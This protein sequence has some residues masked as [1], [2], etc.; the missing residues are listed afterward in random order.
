MLLPLPGTVK[1]FMHPAR[2]VVA[3][4]EAAALEARHAPTRPQR[5]SGR[6]RDIPGLRSSA[7]CI[8]IPPR[9]TCVSSVPLP[10]WP[11]S[12]PHIAGELSGQSN[13]E[14]GRAGIG[15]QSAWPAYGISGTYDLNQSL[16]G[17]AVVGAFGTVS[18]L[19]AWSL[20]HFQREEKYSLFGYGT[21]GVWWHSF[22]TLGTS[23][24]ETSPGL[25]GGAGIELN[26]GGWPGPEWKSEGRVVNGS[27]RVLV[28]GY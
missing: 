19:S 25:S 22:R 28:G 12:S 6:E 16:T 3:V 7:P 26:G 11:Q 15:F 24:S 13:G 14:A 23:D 17:Q 27:P 18:T 20:Y 10:S 8:S 2:T 9:T 5:N 21:A 4:H 1:H